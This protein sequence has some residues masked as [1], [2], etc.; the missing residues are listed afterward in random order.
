MFNLLKLF[1]VFVTVTFE[2]LLFGD[3]QQTD[4]KA[5]MVSKTDC[6]TAGIFFQLMVKNPAKQLGEEKQPIYW[7]FK[8]LRILPEHVSK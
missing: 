8:V 3:K 7:T 2:K 5:C 4:D 6:C 1:A